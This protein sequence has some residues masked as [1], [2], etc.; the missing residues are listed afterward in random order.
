MLSSPE[1][2]ELQRQLTALRF[3]QWRHESL[4]SLQWWF[5]LFLLIAPW[6]IWVKLVERRRVLEISLFGA[7]TIGL[8][9]LMD[10]MGMEL[11]LWGYRYKLTPL[12]PMLLPMDF[13]VLA[14]IHMLIYQYFRPWK[15]FITALT[16]AGCVFAFI[17]EPF[18]EYIGI[19]QRYGWLYIYSLPIYVGKAVACRLIVAT[20]MK[21]NQAR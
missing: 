15:A 7:L 10:A 11:G 20:L 4:F 17:G 19:Y 13:S 1:L 3:E 16:V 8:I 12:L 6:L 21:L 14:V 2:V 5:L 9:T 18:M